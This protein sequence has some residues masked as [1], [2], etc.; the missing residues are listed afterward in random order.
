MSPASPTRA[1]AG[2][3]SAGMYGKEGK[4]PRLKAAS[5]A[6]WL[7]PL[8][9]C[10]AVFCAA[11]C[12]F[13]HSSA[14][15]IVNSSIGKLGDPSRPLAD[16]FQHASRI[17]LQADSSDGV[18]TPQLAWLK[19]PEGGWSSW[20]PQT[21]GTHGNRAG[22]AA[23][24]TSSG[25]HVPSIEAQKL[26]VEQ[27]LLHLSSAVTVQT[28]A[29][30]GTGL[31]ASS[32]VVLTDS[33]TTTDQ[34][35]QKNS[36]TTSAAA[37]AVASAAAAVANGNDAA[38]TTAAF[39]PK[40]SPRPRPAP[41]PRPQLAQ[42]STRPR[43]RPASKRSPPP[44][45]KR[46]PPVAAAAIPAGART[47][48]TPPTVAPAAFHG[49]YKPPTGFSKAPGALP[50]GCPG[51]SSVLKFGATGN[52]AASDVKA[53][54]AADRSGAPFLFFPAGTYRITSN[55]KLTKRV[56]MGLRTKFQ[57][58]AGVVLTLNAQPR[59]A[60]MWYDPMFAGPGRVVMGAGVTEVY[61][62]WWAE[63]PRSDDVVLQMAINSCSVKCTVVQ[64]RTH[65][66]K[67]AVML[68]PR[69]AILATANAGIAAASPSTGEGLILPGGNYLGRH[70]VFTS[71]RGFAKFGIK[72][73][74]GAS[75]LNL[76]AGQITDNYEGIVF[77]S[78]AGR[79]VFNVT[80]SH[81]SVMQ[82]NQH[83]VVFNAP[84]AGAVF[85][86]VTVRLN[87]LLT[88]GFK[89]PGQASSGVLF[90]GSAPTLR[91]T[92]VIMQAID[93]AQF[94][95][96]TQFAA[97]LTRTTAPVSG[98][99]FRSD[100][101][102][103]G[104]HQPGAQVRGAFKNSV[105][106]I[107]FGDSVG[108]SIFSFTPT[109]SNNSMTKMEQ[110]NPGGWFKLV[111]APGTLQQF[112]GANPSSPPQPSPMEFAGPSRHQSFWVS[113]K[114]AGSWAPGVSRTYY[115]HSF[116]AGRG[117][118]SKKMTCN[119]F[120]TSTMGLQCASVSSSPGPNPEDYRRVAVRLTNLSNKIVPD[121]S[122]V[123]FAVQ[124]SG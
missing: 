90:R 119:P 52:G 22:I 113:V 18:D 36:S 43:P 61:P 46:R 10:G 19:E 42:A 79:Q 12:T 104:Y 53:L 83:A 66:L 109:S 16:S 9:L 60:P 51:S 47:S 6:V 94:L 84:G 37:D 54:L 8:L 14:G 70:M 69:V 58:D 48:F 71:V 23:A 123:Y 28:R 110:A 41:R 57:L 59:R 86:G 73:Q 49:Q 3:Q 78:N 35:K 11:T 81:V 91:R 114:T 2:Y 85:A 7:I 40:P 93:P 122:T 39:A 56:V 68:N 33:N 31:Q 15:L 106:Q 75:N 117:I 29:L 121:Q 74:G 17:L 115:L 26:V 120:L 24:A 105:F 101:W 32:L 20:E 30:V 80:L 13:T 118:S 62:A 102:N 96:I 111:P 1:C 97:V 100:C 107:F 4:E 124:V 21:D 98:F 89:S 88:G 63:Y 34:P 72:V 50:A 27:V 95:K 65:F 108:G 76:Q 82:A 92:Q 87:F 44:N 45:P 64:T 77:E 112:L 116:F 67:K 5:T 38:L 55:L 99:V 103:G 25:P